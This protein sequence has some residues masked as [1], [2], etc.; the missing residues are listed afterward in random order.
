M[1]G[2]PPQC[3]Y[4]SSGKDR[5]SAHSLAPPG[6]AESAQGDGLV[7]QGVSRVGEHH[8]SSWYLTTFRA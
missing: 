3:W 2:G 4:A 7:A 6:P 1:V 5:I 8:S